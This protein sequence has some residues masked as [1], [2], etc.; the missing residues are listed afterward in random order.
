MSCCAH[1]ERPPE[2][3]WPLHQADLGL[4]LVEGVDFTVVGGCYEV[5]LTT[6]HT[7]TLGP[8]S[9]RVSSVGR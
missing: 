5:E 1:R 6:E 3:G 2:D 8:S 4:L 7:K 9:F